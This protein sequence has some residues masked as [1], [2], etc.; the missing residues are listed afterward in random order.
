MRAYARAAPLDSAV[1]AR[2]TRVRAI[3]RLTQVIEGER[4]PILE[5]LGESLHP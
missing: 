2:W 1:L 5:R 4:E 3:E